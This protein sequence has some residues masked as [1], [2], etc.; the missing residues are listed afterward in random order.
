M[1]LKSILI[2]GFS[3]VFI[4]QFDKHVTI[5]AIVK[6]KNSDLYYDRYKHLIG[7]S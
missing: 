1:L 3:F 5:P 2:T 4:D 6:I 7:E